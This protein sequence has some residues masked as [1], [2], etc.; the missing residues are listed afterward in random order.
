MQTEAVYPANASAQTEEVQISP[1]LVSP[2]VEPIR[3]IKSVI[4]CDDLVAEQRILQ[5]DKPR[6]VKRQ[7]HA[8]GT[9]QA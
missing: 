4:S 7:E 3:R 2:E 1:A 8:A 6:R 9:E 5:P